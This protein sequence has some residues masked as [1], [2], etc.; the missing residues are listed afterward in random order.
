MDII[1]PSLGQQQNFIL[2]QDIK[3]NVAA[4]QAF[5]NLKIN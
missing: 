3:H 5:E 2:P 4:K 1:E